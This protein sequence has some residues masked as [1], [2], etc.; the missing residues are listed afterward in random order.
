VFTGGGEADLYIEGRID[1]TAEPPGWRAQI[2]TSD[3]AGGVLG[4]RELVD[5]G[6]DCR[7]VDDEL[8]LI[9]A[10]II[11]PDA[12]MVARAPPPPEAP[13]AAPPSGVTA[14]VAPPTAEAPA[15]AGRPWRLAVAG[16]GI[17][18]LGLLPGAALGGRIGATVGPPWS[19]PVELAAALFADGDVA[20]A[21]G[22][23]RFSLIQGSA[24]VCPSVLPVL[25]VCG[26]VALGRLHA[27]GFGFD[28]N[29]E[30]I[31]LRVDAG[32]DARLV[33]PLG[34][35]FHGFLGLGGWVAL[36]RPRFV[37]EQGAGGPRAEL[38]R[39]PPV[40]GALQLGIGFE[41]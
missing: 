1:R 20:R 29:E 19:W 31:E 21:A 14:A 3:A 30:R 33:I 7:V 26:G 5:A 18:A 8:A 34:G 40:A 32:V 37:Y 27:R 4:E 15:R 23:S 2:R 10:L 28:L 16:S 39:P 11:D 25:T 12:V 13:P 24:G 6:A 38:Y 9:V 36:A 41:I 22:G 35:R 17:A